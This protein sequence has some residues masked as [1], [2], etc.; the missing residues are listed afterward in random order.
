MTKVRWTTAAPN[1]L[2]GVINYIRQDNL[3]AAR[4]VAKTACP[5]CE[6]FKN[7]SCI[8]MVENTRELVLGLIQPAKRPLMGAFFRLEGYKDIDDVPLAA[9][10]FGFEAQVEEIV[11]F[12][13]YKEKAC[14][15]IE[16]RKISILNIA[17]RADLL[18]CTIQR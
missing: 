15:G 9:F 5:S 4:R 12:A 13:H 3:E 8:G 16:Q 11:L 14:G 17:F 6:H 1:D 18:R 7:S 2:A 10:N